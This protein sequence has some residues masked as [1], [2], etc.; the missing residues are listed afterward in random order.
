MKNIVEL[1]FI[2]KKVGGGKHQSNIVYSIMG[3]A[4]TICASIG[5]K[6]YMNI[7]TYNLPK[8]LVVALRGRAYRGQKARLEPNFNNICNTLTTVQ[9]DNYILEI[10]SYE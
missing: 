3:L 5:D 9:K 2:P 6:Y 1:G 7:I 4:P 10:T 8:Y